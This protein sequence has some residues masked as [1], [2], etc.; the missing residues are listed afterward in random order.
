M[1]ERVAAD[2]RRLVVAKSPCCANVSLDYRVTGLGVEEV[3]GSVTDPGAGPAA[4]AGGIE[5]ES[6]EESTGARGDVL[7]MMIANQIDYNT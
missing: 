7:G 4:A 6:G 3:E 5:G 2:R 1:L